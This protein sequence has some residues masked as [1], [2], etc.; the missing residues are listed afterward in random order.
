MLKIKCYSPLTTFSYSIITL[1]LLFYDLS[2]GYCPRAWL[3]SW[4]H[5]TLLGACPWHCYLSSQNSYPFFSFFTIAIVLF[6]LIPSVY[7]FIASIICSV[8]CFLLTYNHVLIWVTFVMPVFMPVFFAAE[9]FAVYTFP[10]DLVVQ[11][12]VNCWFL[13]FQ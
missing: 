4:F 9:L 8:L 1:P 5:N 7:R 13:S 6:F 10:A 2:F 12:T 11:Y 3:P